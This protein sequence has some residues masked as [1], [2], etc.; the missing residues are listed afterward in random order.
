MS[1]LRATASLDT[2][3]DAATLGANVAQ[4]AITNIIDSIFFFIVFLL[5]ATIFVVV[6]LL[7]LNPSIIFPKPFFKY[8]IEPPISSSFHIQSMI[9]FEHYD[10]ILSLL[11]NKLNDMIMP[12]E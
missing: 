7:T 10:D 1:V 9:L 6:I 5:L 8:F 3:V 2:V 4:R 12:C 11:A